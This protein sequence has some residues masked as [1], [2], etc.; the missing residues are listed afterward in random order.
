MF[1]HF[2][3]ILAP[4][5]GLNP[6]PRVNEFHNFGKGFYGHQNHAFSFSQ[7]YNGVKNK[8]ILDLINTFTIEP[9]CSHPRV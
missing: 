4:S 5:Y 2:M 7:I 6:C 8:I 9:Y 1:F 3:A